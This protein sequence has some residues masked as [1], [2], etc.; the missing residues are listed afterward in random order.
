MFLKEASRKLWILREKILWSLDHNRVKHMHL[1]LIVSI[2]GQISELEE[3]SSIRN[4]F[5]AHFMD[6]SMMAKLESVWVK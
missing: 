4:A 2:L 3:R 1:K 5:N 6:G